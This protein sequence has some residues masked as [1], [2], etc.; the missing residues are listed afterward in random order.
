MLICK[1]IGFCVTLA[2]YRLRI[3]SGFPQFF[4]LVKLLL[5]W[6]RSQTFSWYLSYSPKAWK[7]LNQEIIFKITFM[8]VISKTLNRRIHSFWQN[9]KCNVSVIKKISVLFQTLQFF[10]FFCCFFFCFF[11]CY[12]NYVNVSTI[13]QSELCVCVC[14]CVCVCLSVIWLVEQSTILVVLYSRSQSCILWEKTLRI[15]DFHGAK[16]RNLLTKYELI[17]IYQFRIIFDKIN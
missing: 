5:P 15:I 11:W 6:N 17:L 8:V 3:C 4:T 16:K 9:F 10:C 7:I 2:W 13:Y 12:Q 1:S 14:V